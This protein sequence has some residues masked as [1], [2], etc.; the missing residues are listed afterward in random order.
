MVV[1]YQR[2]QKQRQRNQ[3]I[4]SSF[5]FSDLN[6]K[7]F[8]I[9]NKQEHLRLATETN[10][11]CCFN[12]I[13]GLPVKDKVKHPIYDYEK[14]LYDSLMNPIE[15][16]SKDFKDKHLWVKKATGLGVTEFML[17]LMAWLCTKDSWYGDSQMCIVTGPNIDI[18]TKLIKRLKAIFESKLGVIFQ[19]KETVFELNGC[20]IEAYPSNHLD[21]YSSLENPKFILIDEGDFFRKSEQEDVR[22]VTE[23]YIGKSDHTL[24][25]HGINA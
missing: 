21:A 10:E 24:H 5:N 17:R 23:R 3:K 9:W 15:I 25:C 1:P 11:H 2:H 22:F 7:P 18:A 4:E 20:T 6:G 13:V 12:H 14:I 8:W 19:N 16:I